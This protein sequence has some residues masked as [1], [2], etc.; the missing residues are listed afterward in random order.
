MRKIA[1]TLL[2]ALFAWGATAQDQVN[3]EISDGIRNATLKQRMETNL[4]RLLTAIN[5]ASSQKADINFTGIGISD[6]ASQSLTSLW[7]NARFHCLDD[8]IVEHGLSLKRAGRVYQY[9]VRNI[10]VEMEAVDEAYAD[11]VNQEVE[12]DFDL[13]G[14]II[15]F[16]ISI[17]KH[18]YTRILKEGFD[19]GDADER[20]EIIG[21]C[22]QLKNAYKRKDIKMLDDIFSDD[23]LIVTGKV[24]TRVKRETGTMQTDVV[25]D[26]KPKA[27]YLANLRKIFTNPKT[28]EVHVEFD[29]Y[30]IKRHGAKPNFYVV[31]LD[32]EW[33][34][35]TYKDKGIVILLW[36]FK[37]REHPQ[38]LVRTWQP[39]DTDV[40]KGFDY[41][42]N[43]HFN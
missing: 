27:Q 5:K 26:P 9:Q 43:L 41:I 12:V 11:D 32:Q 17:D 40:Q 14:K 10:P 23:A 4:S 38:I 37:D 25:F 24:M 6:M 8:D 22:T 35:N 7:A 15:D 21:F 29:G 19:V 18:Q 28:G 36:D 39:Q 20:L 42:D 33:A 3:V 2:V 34:T 16:N 1:L 13:S 31:V 30:K